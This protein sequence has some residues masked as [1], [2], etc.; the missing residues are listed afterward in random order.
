MK[1]FNI[2]D[3]P[4]PVIRLVFALA[5]KQPAIIL[6]APP[7]PS[8]HTRERTLDRFTAYDTPALTMFTD[9]FTTAQSPSQYIIQRPEIVD[10]QPEGFTTPYMV[11]LLKILRDMHRPYLCLNMDENIR[12]WHRYGLRIR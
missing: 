7:R 1:V 5:S 9:A 4:R 2:G 12:Q 6:F 10:S 11:A 3:A 8:K